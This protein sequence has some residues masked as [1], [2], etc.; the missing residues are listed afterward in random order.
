M[1]VSNKTDPPIPP[2]P[3]IPTRNALK[4][5]LILGLFFATFIASISALVLKRAASASANSS[6]AQTI[7]SLISCFGG[8]VFLATCLMHLLPESME[9]IDKG[10]DALKLDFD[11]PLPEF[12]ISLGFMFVMFVEQAAIFAHEQEWIG[13]GQNILGH[14]HE[15]T[16]DTV[17]ILEEDTRS[18]GSVRSERRSHAGSIMSDDHFE[19]ETHSTM[20][21]ALL[22]MAI[23]LH[24]VFE[25]LSVG[26]IQEVSALLQI[27]GALLIH[28]VVIGISLGVRLVQSNMKPTGVVIC[29]IIF[30]GQIVVG[31]FIGLGIM[32]ILRGESIGLTNFIGGILQAF[33]AGTFLYIT[34]F[35]I[36]PHELNKPGYR[37][38]K[39]LFLSA[40]FALITFFISYFPDADDGN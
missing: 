31:G 16:E 32:D 3:Y 30:A 2:G 13:Q 11:F 37:P 29:C 20:R 24:A 33:A 38:L 36:L 14:G 1:D 27:C 19:H 17:P 4:S 23:S 18:N 40:G 22:V 8:G 28:K 7:F 15:H 21:A 35:E 10:Q 25:G 34:C 5:V 39:L 12:C 6:R 9:Q 26:M